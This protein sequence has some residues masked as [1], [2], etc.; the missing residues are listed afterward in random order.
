LNY[1]FDFTVVWRS[2]NSLILGLALDL[3][4]AFAS[5][6]MG[7]IIGLFVAFALVSKNKLLRRSSSLYVTIIRNTPILI[8]ILFIFFALPD[9]GITFNQYQSFIIA[10]TI[11]AGAYIAEVFRGGILAVPKGIHET[12]LALGMTSIQTN[13]VVI[14][15]IIIRT[16]LASM[17]NNFI[18]LFKD[19][20]LAATIA[21]PELTFYTR[22]INVETFRVIEAWS[23]TSVIYVLTCLTIA[24]LLRKVERRYAIVR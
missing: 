7:S 20:S 3:G 17:S 21:V 18:S 4:M 23:V 1:T 6:L 13:R 24:A 15:P 16:T 5:I 2:F 9:L 19:T 22:K 12:G 14:V 11:Y 10:L 8:I